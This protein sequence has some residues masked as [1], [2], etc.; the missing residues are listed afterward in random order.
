LCYGCGGLPDTKE[1]RRMG[2]VDDFREHA[3]RLRAN[4][5]MRR[6]D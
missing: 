6:N 4:R 2:V 1:P 3:N 5:L